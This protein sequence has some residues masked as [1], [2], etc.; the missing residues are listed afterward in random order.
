M[1]HLHFEL[2]FAPSREEKTLFTKAVVQGF[3]Q[4]MDTG[5]DHVAVT[6]RSCEPEDLAFGRA[7]GDGRA[8]VVDAD[9]RY[10]RSTDQKRRLAL[11][12]MEEVERSFRVPQ[13]SVYVV[14]TEH[15]GASFQLSD[16]VL[17]SWSPGE[18]PLED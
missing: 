6:L 4:I 8:V 7:Q 18:K 15:D 9:I 3:A 2:N 10:G 13:R 1:P 17:P 5:T 11:R 14:Y 16:R 12:V